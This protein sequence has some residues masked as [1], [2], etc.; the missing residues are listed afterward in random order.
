MNE[1]EVLLRV[2]LGCG[3]LAEAFCD[4]RRHCNEVRGS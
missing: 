2:Q 3:L 1:A 4:L